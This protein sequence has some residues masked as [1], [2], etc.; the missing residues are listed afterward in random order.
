MDVGK[1]RKNKESSQENEMKQ[2]G[3]Q[4]QQMITQTKW[5]KQNKAQEAEATPQPTVKPSK[6]APTKPEPK[7]EEVIADESMAPEE[8]DED[9]IEDQTEKD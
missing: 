1:W 7:Q 8:S 9:V 3:N 4:V 2:V 6:K 5:T